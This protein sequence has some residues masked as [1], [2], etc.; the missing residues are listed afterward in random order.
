MMKI[1]LSF[2]LLPGLGYLNNNKCEQLF[3]MKI[4]VFKYIRFVYLCLCIISCVF[5]QK[6]YDSLQEYTIK[7]K[8]Y[9]YIIKVKK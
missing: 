7:F 8:V 9:K 3:Q 2:A 4:S 5:P 6:L 1:V